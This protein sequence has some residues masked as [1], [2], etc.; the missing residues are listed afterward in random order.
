MSCQA[1]ATAL[2]FTEWDATWASCEQ[3]SRARGKESAAI[4]RQIGE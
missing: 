3:T 1:C 4:V 2:S